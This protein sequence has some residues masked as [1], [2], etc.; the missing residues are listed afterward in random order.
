MWRA[1]NL[2]AASTLAAGITFSAIGVATGTVALA[3]FGLV[4]AIGAVTYRTRAN[5]NY[6]VTCTV[7]PSTATIVVEPT[8]PR[9]DDAARELFVRTL[10]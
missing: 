7:H 9:F 3:V 1:R 2:A 5:H 10:N 6:W 4:I 8:H